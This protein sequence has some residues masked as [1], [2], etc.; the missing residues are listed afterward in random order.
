[1]FSRR[2]RVIK[3]THTKSRISQERSDR[4][5]TTPVVETCPSRLSS[6]AQIIAIFR[7]CSTIKT[8]TPRTIDMPQRF[9]SSYD[10]RRKAEKYLVSTN[11][12][13]GQDTC[14]VKLQRS[15]EALTYVRWRAQIICTENRQDS[16]MSTITQLLD[17]LSQ[18]SHRNTIIKFHDFSTTIY[19]LF[20]DDRKANTEDHRPYSPHIR[21]E[22]Q[23][24][25]QTENK[26]SKR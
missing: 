14:E 26:E 12:G 10:R 6:F 8:S 23:I 20:H 18:G 13:G 16:D 11:C 19:A 7:S 9:D 17:M 4:L 2:S 1:M 5:E 15:R 21:K 22:S 24:S 3:N 25:F